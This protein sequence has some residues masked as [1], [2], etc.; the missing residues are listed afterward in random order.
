MNA[1]KIFD[2]VCSENRRELTELEAKNVL[3]SYNIPVVQTELATTKQEATKLA[4]ELGYPVVLKIASPDILHKVDAGGVKTML[5]TDSEVSSAFTEIIS[6][7]KSYDPTA[8]I[9]GATIQHHIPR[10]VEV[11]I[12]GLKDP[13]FGPCVMFG[14]GGTWV[15]IMNDVSFRLAPTSK[16]KAK[17]MTHDIKAYP[18]LTRY[19]GLEG[20]N[21][22]SIAD[23][24]VK[25][26]N[27]M[28]ENDIIAEVDVNPV[29]ARANSSIAVDARIVLDECV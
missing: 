25:V 18:L 16:K 4:N 7:A 21:I 23:I 6:N 22:D 27:L 9:L 14:M 26:S 10:G 8:R 11:I 20:V 3:E 13:V 2:Q 15:E 29:F 1:K 24:I 5:K 19:R 12:G 28:F 17:E